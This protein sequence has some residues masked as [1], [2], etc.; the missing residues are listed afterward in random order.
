MR[1]I[2]VVGLS[3]L[4]TA[5]AWP[6]ERSNVTFNDCEGRAHTPLSQSDKKATVLKS[7]KLG[8]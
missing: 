8:K 2:A 4:L 1:S 5:M 7:F 6:G 3:L